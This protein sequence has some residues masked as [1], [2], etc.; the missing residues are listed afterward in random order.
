MRSS[1]LVWKERLPTYRFLLKTDPF[2][3]TGPAPKN[4]RTQV[5]TG[6]WHGIRSG[7]SLGDLSSFEM[8]CRERREGQGK[9]GRL[10]RRVWV[11]TCPPD[12]AIITAP[13]EKATSIP[14]SFHP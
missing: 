3:G 4:S 14:E 11:G 9:A 12:G 1:A 5:P 8:G 10:V 13:Q 6:T 2:A 7:E